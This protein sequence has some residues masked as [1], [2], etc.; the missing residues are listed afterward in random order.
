MS[1]FP[2]PADDFTVLSIDGT[3]SGERISLEVFDAAG[4]LI[5]TQSINAN[6]NSTMHR[7]DVNSYARG[8]YMIVVQSGSER[9]V[10]RLVK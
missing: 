7:L 3:S 8:V 9:F 10:Q 2:N 1:M 4:R 6:G 5:E